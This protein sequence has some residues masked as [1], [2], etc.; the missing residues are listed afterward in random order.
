VALAYFPA[1][2]TMSTERLTA[3]PAAVRAGLERWPAGAFTRL[4]ALAAARI[5]AEA[6]DA[7]AAA[8]G[9]GGGGGTEQ[10]P[11]PQAAPE[12]AADGEGDGADAADGDAD[13]P[14]AA[15]GE[16]EA[17]AAAAAAPQ[18]QPQLPDGPLP[19]GRAASL[20]SAFLL[21]QPQVLVKDPA[22]VAA[23]WA[24]VDAWLEQSPG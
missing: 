24:Q 21:A 1:L 12:Q 19:P 7:A 13:G 17:A 5:E 10:G 4:V 20:A 2:L 18:Q 16:G 22:A 6:A 11:Q 23:R 15:D 8:A 14:D 3:L 9:G